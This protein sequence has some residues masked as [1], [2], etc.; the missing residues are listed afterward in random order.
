MRMLLNLLFYFRY[1]NSYTIS[2]VAP[3]LEFRDA[4]I[5]AVARAF[6]RAV[7]KTPKGS[8]TLSLKWQ[9]PKSET[10]RW[11]SLFRDVQTLAASLRVVDFCVTQSSLEE[12]F[13]RLSLE[14]E[15]DDTSSS[16]TR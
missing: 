16:L 4:V 6:P 1:G 14:S 11:S 10:D 15:E 9:I 5:D 2:M 7:L 13:L 3:G 8:L 12:T